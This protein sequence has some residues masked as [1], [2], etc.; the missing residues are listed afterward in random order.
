MDD[1][2][3]A[4]D[5]EEAFF[6]DDFFVDVVD[7]VLPVVSAAGASVAVAVGAGAPGT[8]STGTMTSTGVCTSGTVE[9]PLVRVE[10]S[11]IEM[12]PVFA[13]IVPT[14]TPV[15]AVI[16]MRRRGT[17]MFMSSVSQPPDTRTTRFIQE[18]SKI[19][20]EPFAPRCRRPPFVAQSYI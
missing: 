7:P 10:R 11:L 14:P 16:P 20:Q 3:L 5:P 4:V 12:A 15:V 2:L 13:A 6:A 1:E 17:W 18:T 8:S 19:P 9:A